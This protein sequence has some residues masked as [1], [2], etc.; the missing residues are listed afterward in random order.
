M[1]RK[2]LLILFVLSL[3][4]FQMS[5]K[6]FE[7]GVKGGVTLSNLSFKGDFT[8]N[9]SSDNRAGF[10]VGPMV[11]A[12]LPLGFN[13][14]AAVMY[15]FDK[16]QYSDL[17]GGVTDKRHIIEMPVN[18]KWEISIAKIIGV[19]VA[20]GPDFAFN[21]NKGSEIES[22]IKGSLEADGIDS[23]VLKNE[24][25][26]LSMGIG[27]G[28]GIILFDHLNIGFNYIFPVDYTYKYV[29]GETGLE[30]STKAKRWQISAAYMF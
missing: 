24:T 15:A 9:F 17:K 20:A 1:K 16:V 3:A 21:L 29:L 11:N 2:S 18:L 27:L 23:S 26:S 4:V 22:Y 5:A 30:F 7:F 14:D 19:Y 12:S 25:K 13:V 6:N 8:K 10:F 28:A